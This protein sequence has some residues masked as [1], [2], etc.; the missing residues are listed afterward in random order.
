[1]ILF[2]LF[3]LNNAI[4]G[5]MFTIIAYMG[6]TLFSFLMLNRKISMVKKVGILLVAVFSLIILQNAKLAYR[7]QIWINSYQGNKAALFGELLWKNIE[8]GDNLIT[9]DALFPVYS[10]TNQGF[11]VALVMLNIP[12]T[13]PHDQGSRLVTVAASAFVPRFLWPDKPE[14]GGVYNMKYYA[15]FQIKNW[16]TNV[17]PL[18]EAY[19][20]FGVTGG[21]IYMF[22]LGM[23]LRWAYFRILV[24]STRIPVLICWLPVLFYQIIYSAETDTLQI[25]NSLVKSAFFLC[26]IYKLLPQWFGI[27]KQELTFDVNQPVEYKA[28]SR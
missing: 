19:G 24:I 8:R 1:M 2:G 11:N 17:G 14:A 3:I 6:I 20:A 7:K 26:I 15:G 9:T 23:F 5:G 10:R 18:G 16:S 13:K 4:S 28:Q 25:L 22:L 27:K 12:K 21:I